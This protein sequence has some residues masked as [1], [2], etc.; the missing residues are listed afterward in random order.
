MVVRAPNKF[1]SAAY[2]GSKNSSNPLDYLPEGFLQRTRDQGLVIPSWAPQIQILSHNSIG[3]FLSHCGWNSILQ[4]LQKGVPLIAFPLFAEQRMNACLL[5]DLKAA[6]RPKVNE[7]GIVKWEEIGESI[8]NLMEGEEGKEIYKRLRDL[9]DI[10]ANA[11]KEDGSSAKA[12]RQVALIWKNL[13][14]NQK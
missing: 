2:F 14:G 4:S 13:D 11:L 10:V 8:K 9:K 7:D 6:L 1:A 12:L 5:T 3:G